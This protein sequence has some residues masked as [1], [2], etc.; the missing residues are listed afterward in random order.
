M[1]RNEITELLST[2]K[3][4]IMINDNTND[5]ELRYLMD[6]LV[7]HIPFERPDAYLV[8]GDVVFCIEHFKISQYKHKRKGDI[9]QKAESSKKN[10]DKLK[11]DETFDLQP[12]LDNLCDS[13]DSALKKHLHTPSIYRDNVAEIVKAKDYRLVLL[14]EDASGQGVYI[15]KFNNTSRNPI[16]FD[17]IASNLLMYQ[18]DVWGVLIV[19]GNSISKGMWGFTCEELNKFKS[20]GSLL[21]ITKYR[22]MYIQETKSIS[23][24]DAGKDLHNVFIEL[25]DGF[26]LI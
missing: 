1:S 14:I 15:E 9:G 26:R 20:C 24:D 21:D 11:D 8:H 2:S 3:I 4:N 13:L 17:K 5:P 19:C 18:N 22:P 23:K 16:L 10:R 12:S 25:N 7:C 6:N